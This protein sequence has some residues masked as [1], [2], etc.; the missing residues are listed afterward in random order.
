VAVRCDPVVF[1]AFIRMMNMLETPERAFGRP[2][3]VLRALWVL[4]QGERF[5]RRYAPPPA[6]DRERTIARCEAAV[7]QR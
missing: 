3:V 6:P 2:E 5:R 7:A 1:R 4:A